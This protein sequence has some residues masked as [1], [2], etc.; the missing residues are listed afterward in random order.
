MRNPAILILS[1]VGER[2]T[3]PDPA[4]PPV[5]DMS[6]LG[7]SFVTASGACRCQVDLL[8]SVQ[9]RPSGKVTRRLRCGLR[10]RSLIQQYPQFTVEMVSA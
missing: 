2:G 1:Q 3:E 6:R 9:Y 10:E 8:A 4:G 5:E 7:A